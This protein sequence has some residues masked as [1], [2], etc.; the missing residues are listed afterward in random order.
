MGL[1]ERIV[2]VQNYPNYL[3]SYIGDKSSLTLWTGLCTFA[4]VR[5]H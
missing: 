4:Y 3:S 2:S 5:L 1:I